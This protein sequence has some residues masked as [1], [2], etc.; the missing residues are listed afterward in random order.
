MLTFAVSSRAASA[1][2][3][4]IQI[5]VKQNGL[6]RPNRQHRCLPTV[7]AAATGEMLLDRRITQAMP[8]SRVKAELALEDL[9]Q[10]NQRFRQGVLQNCVVDS[11]RFE[12]L[13]AGQA[14]PAIVLCCSDSRVPPEMVL[15]QGMGDVFV[16]RVAG[17]I[18]E[19]HVL[20]S[21]LYAI[22]N[23]G[24]RL[25]M[26]MGHSKCGACTAAQGAFIAS[27]SGERCVSSESDP[28]SILLTRLLDPCNKLVD[29]ASKN[30]SAKADLKSILPVEAVVKENAL[31]VAE[32]TLQGLQ[33]NLA[34]QETFWRSDISI[35][36]IG[37]SAR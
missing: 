15:D 18:L 1:I 35:R 9:I 32:I 2:R 22:G 30:G 20:A 12:E 19:D 25:V 11:R 29:R 5:P 36:I 33:D 23:L 26:V 10:G 17:N 27:K 21:M 37:A 4:V 8:A 3:P 24:S 14:P 16:I 6:A 34:G 31:H 28:I 13:T 7:Q